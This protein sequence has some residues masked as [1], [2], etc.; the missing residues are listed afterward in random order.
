MA[1][2]TEEHF[3]GAPAI[4]THSSYIFSPI[5]IAPVLYPTKLEAPFTTDPGVTGDTS[6]LLALSIIFPLTNL[7][8]ANTSISPV[9]GSCIITL[10]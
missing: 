6:I 5:L 7:L 9:L 1:S 2:K 4:L 3:F 10:E 8:E